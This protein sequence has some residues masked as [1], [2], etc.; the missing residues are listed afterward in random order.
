MLSK[1]ILGTLSRETAIRAHKR[2]KEKALSQFQVRDQF[3]EDIFHN[4]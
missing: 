2:S 3:I 4:I 1:H